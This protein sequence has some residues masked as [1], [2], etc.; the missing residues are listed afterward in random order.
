MPEVSRRQ[1]FKLVGAAGALS[2]VPAAVA[3]ATT[4]TTITAPTA[5]MLVRAVRI[6]PRGF[7]GIKVPGGIIDMTMPEKA[8]RE[9]GGYEVVELDT[10][11]DHQLKYAAVSVPEVLEF[12]TEMDM[13]WVDSMHANSLMQVKEGDESVTYWQI[14][15]VQLAGTEAEAEAEA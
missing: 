15:E 1:L 4:P 12:E 3:S 2:L 9:E 6:Y 7:L 10:P 8:K 13:Q 14:T 11:E 5:R